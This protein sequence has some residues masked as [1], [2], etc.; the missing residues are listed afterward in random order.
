MSVR[1]R[2]K[3]KR[4]ENLYTKEEGA[5]RYS[6]AVVKAFFETMAI[7]AN[8]KDERELYSFKSLRFEALKGDRAGDHSVRLNKQFRLTMRIEKGDD[9]NTV[10]L[11]DIEDY[12]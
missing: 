4:L 8:I 1:F 11:L 12:H 5:R 3:E 7:I 9:G 6:S 10:L 2:F